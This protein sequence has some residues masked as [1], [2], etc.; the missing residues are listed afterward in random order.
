MGKWQNLYVTLF[1][2]RKEN[3]GYHGRSSERDDSRGN[4]A[5]DAGKREPGA[6]DT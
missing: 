5:S 4:A 2:M 3:R 1:L 6:A